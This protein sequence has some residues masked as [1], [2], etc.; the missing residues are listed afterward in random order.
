MKRQVRPFNTQ[1]IIDVLQGTLKKA[2]VQKSLDSLVSDGKVMAK[3]Y[4]KQ[5]IYCISQGLFETPSAAKFSELELQTS[6]ASE[7]LQ[8]L[9][10]ET[11]VLSADVRKLQSTLT[12]EELFKREQELVAETRNMETRLVQ[13]R[14]GAVLVTPEQR[15]RAQA[16]Y[17]STR[18]AWRKRK[19]LCMDVVRM[20]AD[21]MQTKVAEFMETVG[22]ES[23]ESVGVLFDATAVGV[24]KRSRP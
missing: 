7:Q 8:K 21:N 13:L 4:G 1:M 19:A 3:D 16:Q 24:P 5:K 2:Q 12:E 22:V 10:Q 9:Q 15:Q 18:G 17:E 23:D 14:S 11:H 20:I 6:T